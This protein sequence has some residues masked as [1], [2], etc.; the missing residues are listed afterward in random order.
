GEIEGEI[1]FAPKGVGGFGYDP[2]F[3]VESEGMTTAEMSQ[4][5]KNQISHRAKSLEIMAKK[6]RE[7]L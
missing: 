6:L 1:L 4:E 2:V 5:R 3:Y 7:V